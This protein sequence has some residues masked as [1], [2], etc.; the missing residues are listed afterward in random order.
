MKQQDE[1]EKQADRR[2][3]L[4][5]LCSASGLLLSVVCCIALIHV[6]LA[7]QEHHRLISNSVTFCDQMK[8]EILRKVQQNYGSRQ[9]MATGRHWQAT[10]GE[11]ETVSRQKRSAPDDSQQQSTLTASEVQMLI[12]QELGLLQNQVCAK[13]HTL[14]RTGAKGS[15]GRR[16]RPGTRGR[17]GPPGRPG[18]NGPPGKHGPIGPQGPMG[19]KG[20]LGLPETL[21][22][23]GL[24]A[25]RV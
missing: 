5:R 14:C 10:K 24:E 11:Q 2:Q 1:Q 15:T 22:P 17:P 3:T 20:D 4:H 12:K 23:R 9:V 21:V 25:P 16:G 6:Q 13:D 8:T 18:L 7:I 19:M